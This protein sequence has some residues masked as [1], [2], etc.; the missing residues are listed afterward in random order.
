MIK[1]NS[2]RYG[3]VSRFLHWGMALLAL[4]Q[5][6]SAGAHYLLEDSAVEKL[7][8]PLHKPVGFCI[9]VLIIFRIIWAL[10][11]AAKRPR[12]IN[13]LSKLGHISLY[14]L[15]LLVPTVALIRQYGSGRAFEPLGLPIFSGFDG[16]K[17]QWMIDL[18]SQWHGLLG[19]I[20]FLLIVGHIAMAWVHQK[21]PSKENV[22]KRMWR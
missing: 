1:D 20:L 21:S 13:L 4:L 15:L 18:G 22:L 17:I 2:V 14:L 3:T 7:L 5:L 16:D 12:S 8:W 6:L 11:H 9:F 10:T 19:W